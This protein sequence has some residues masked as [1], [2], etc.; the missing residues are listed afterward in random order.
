MICL[1]FAI[2]QCDRYVELHSQEG[3]Y[4]RLRI[5]KF[6]CDMK[7]HYPTCDLIIGGH[8]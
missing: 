4:Y 1:K 5:P 2:L 3:R 7:Y 8:R 6:G